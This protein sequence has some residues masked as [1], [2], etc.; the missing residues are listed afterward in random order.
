MSVDY[1]KVF[2]NLP[3]NVQDVILSKD[4]AQNI[5]DICINQGIK[6]SVI[7]VVSELVGDVLMGILQEPALIQQLTE[8]ANITG[9]ASKEIADAISREVLAPVRSSIPT[10]IPD[11]NETPPIPPYEQTPLR[12]SFAKDE[13]LEFLRTGK[14]PK[15]PTPP[16]T[17]TPTPSPAPQQLEKPIKVTPLTVNFT[18]S[19]TS[20]ITSKPIEQAIKPV[21]PT[22][23][24]ITQAAPPPPPSI[25]P[26]QQTQ[27]PVSQQETNKQ[28]VNI[29]PGHEAP[30]IMHKEEE[31][32]ANKEKPSP[33]SVQRPTFYKPVFSEEYKTVLGG[34]KTARVELGSEEEKP[35]SS[36]VYK[37][38][39]QGPRVVHYSEFRTE[40]SP[41]ENQN[42]NQLPAQPS[43]KESVLPAT[44]PAKPTE[45]HPNNIIDLKDLPLK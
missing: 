10:K 6:E 4:T 24:T 45:V 39:S 43:P 2:N 34:N 42:K 13:S 29:E 35:R 27:A 18:P 37:T 19:T 5:K 22:P 30:F 16:A 38:P 21:A 23:A 32:Q 14:L 28:E 1:L 9:T 33:Y 7:P 31:V 17:P 26:A 40:V 12:P 15:P 44:P 3:E 8:K 41:F 20:Q 11:T 25:T 36:E